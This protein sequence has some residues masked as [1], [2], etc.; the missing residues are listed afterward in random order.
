[1]RNL[2]YEITLWEKQVPVILIHN[3]SIATIDRVQNRY[4]YGK[5]RPI[6]RKYNTVRSYL[7]SSVINMDYVK[8]CCNAVDPLTKALTRERV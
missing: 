7:S 5:S 8:L 4:Y 3:D 1:M 6:R 2:L